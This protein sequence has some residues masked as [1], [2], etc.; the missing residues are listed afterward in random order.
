MNKNYFLLIAVFS[1]ALF[2]TTQFSYAYT[3]DELCPPKTIYNSFEGEVDLP[4]FRCIVENSVQHFLAE[5]LIYHEGIIDESIKIKILPGME[6]PMPPP[7]NVRI[8]YDQYGSDEIRHMDTMYEVK[9]FHPPNY[10]HAELIPVF[11]MLHQPPNLILKQ[12]EEMNASPN[13]KYY[14]Q[15]TMCREGFDR[16]VKESTQ[17]YVCVFSDSVEELVDRGYGRSDFIVAKHALK[18]L[19]DK[20]SINGS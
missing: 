5:E 3:E 19:P 6:Q 20:V 4:D 13:V 12:L 8:I 2:G 1:I 17:K 9:F 11:S 16:L 18:L 10:Q 15:N 7:F 14:Y